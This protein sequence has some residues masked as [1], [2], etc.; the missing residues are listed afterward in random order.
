MALAGDAPVGASQGA[1]GGEPETDQTSRISEVLDL[2]GREILDVLSV[3]ILRISG[4]D[5]L[6]ICCYFVY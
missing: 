4:P 1:L 5:S 2:P 6:L 3:L